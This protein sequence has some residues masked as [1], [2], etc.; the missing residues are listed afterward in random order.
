LA[1]SGFLE[2]FQCQGAKAAQ[3]INLALAWIGAKDIAQGFMRQIEK[4][5]PGCNQSP[6][7]SY[8]KLGS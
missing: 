1:T 3:G 5:M 8:L 2:D 4:S 6:Q 7:N